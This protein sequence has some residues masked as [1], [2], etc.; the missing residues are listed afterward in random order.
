M[1]R[2]QT[3][4]DGSSLFQF[5]EW[6][7]RKNHSSTKFWWDYEA[8]RFELDPDRGPRV[9]SCDEDCRPI[10]VLSVDKGSKGQ[11]GFIT[12]LE[13]A[14]YLPIP[15]SHT[16]LR[17]S[18][19]PGGS[20]YPSPTISLST[21][22]ATMMWLFLLKNPDEEITIKVVSHDYMLAL[23]MQSLQGV[24]PSCKMKLVYPGSGLDPRWSNIEDGA[25][26]ECKIEFVDLENR[27]PTLIPNYIPAA[28]S[29]F[30]SNFFPQYP[31]NP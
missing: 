8:L 22:I 31:W 4:I 7:K 13:E 25:P 23:P 11:S 10:V 5:L 27:L 30:P 15:L 28:T 9:R 21:H 12:M 2:I 1:S 14:G 17:P 29:D 18:E 26:A 16:N 19:A 6:Q 24:Y 3:F 20:R